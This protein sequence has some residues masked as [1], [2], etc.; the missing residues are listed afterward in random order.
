YV[1]KDWAELAIEFPTKVETIASEFKAG[2]AVVDPVNGK[3][4]CR[5]CALENLCRIDELSKSEIDDGE[6]LS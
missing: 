5:Y 1:K 2:C 4:T 3:L 6:S